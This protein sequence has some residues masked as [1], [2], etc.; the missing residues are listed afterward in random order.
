VQSQQF[1]SVAQADER[2]ELRE[3]GRRTL[4]KLRKQRRAS[5]ES[6][7]DDAV[8]GSYEQLRWGLVSCPSSASDDSCKMSE[9]C[10]LSESGMHSEDP[11]E[12]LHEQVDCLMAHV[13]TLVHEREQW[14]SEAV[15]LRRELESLRCLVND[16]SLE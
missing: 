14:Q 11:S 2:F 7:G 16:V 5:T 1:L 4:A 12:E 13:N 8:V 6:T 9:A 10:T 3:V 15:R